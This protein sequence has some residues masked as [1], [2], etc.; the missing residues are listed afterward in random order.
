[1]HRYTFSLHGWP[2]HQRM[3]QTLST[4]IE[5]I[6]SR[7]N[8]VHFQGVQHFQ[9]LH[10]RQRE[11]VRIQQWLS[12]QSLCAKSIN[13]QY[14]TI[15]DKPF[16]N[17]FVFAKNSCLN[18]CWPEEWVNKYRS[19]GDGDIGEEWHLQNI[20]LKI[21][22]ETAFDV[23]KRQKPNSSFKKGFFFFFSNFCSQE[24]VFSEELELLTWSVLNKHCHTAEQL[25][26]TSLL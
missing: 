9:G 10:A 1:M 3:M 16:L 6:K 22:S 7:P 14:I 8:A 21:C 11:N 5:H 17:L 26:R 23:E 24:W 18:M 15:H 13:R 20:K 19:A 12:V 4:F 2:L 25:L